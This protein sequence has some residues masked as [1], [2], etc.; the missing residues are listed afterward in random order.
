[1]PTTLYRAIS[2]PIPENPLGAI[3]GFETIQLVPNPNFALLPNVII[4]GSS[5]EFSVSHHISIDGTDFNYL[6]LNWTHIASTELSWPVVPRLS[7]VMPECNDFIY[8]TQ[9]FPWE[10]EILPTDVNITFELGVELFGDFATIEE[11]GLMFKV[12]IWLIDSSGNWHQVYR[13][14]PPYIATQ[15]V[16]HTNLNY[17]DIVESWGGMIQ[18]EDGV[19]EDPD[20]NLTIAVGLA[21]TAWFLEVFETEPWREYDG[22]VTATIS[23]LDLTVIL[24]TEADISPRLHPRS[25]NSLSSKYMDVCEDMCVT[26]DGAV[27]TVGTK[28]HYPTVNS[29][30][31]VKWDSQANLQWVQMW[32]G[33][34]FAS[35]YG[36]VESQGFV[37]TVGIDWSGHHEGDLVILKWDPSGELIWQESFDN[38]GLDCGRKIEIGEDGV[39]Y[40]VGDTWSPRYLT[41]STFLAKFDSEGNKLWF[42]EISAVPY[43]SWD[44][45]L[46]VA[47]TVE[48]KIY[49]MTSHYLTLWNADGDLQWIISTVYNDL[50]VGPDG[51]AYLVGQSYS[52]N[53]QLDKVNEIGELD[54][55]VTKNVSYGYLKESISGVSVDVAPDGSIYVVAEL[56]RY[57]LAYLLIKYDAEGQ[58]VW[59]RT[60]GKDS[61]KHAYGGGRVCHLSARGSGLLYLATT[62]LAEETEGNFALAIYDFRPTD[63]NLGLNTVN[64]GLYLAASTL[65]LFVIIDHARRKR[66]WNSG[67]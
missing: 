13:T 52:S 5:G 58:E 26:S 40:V 10:R 61:W 56:Y 59:N 55:S 12:Y 62:I 47:V 50:A 51:S 35:G 21:P 24:E 16:L 65:I 29:L 25:N 8:F 20:D 66:R 23:R 39:I 11:G 18:D 31:L 1:M 45:G 49:A 57:D 14:S 36:V 30:V 54:W 44:Q 34:T 53:M 2:V 27:Y 17:F 9:T 43:W 22:S 42:R 38:N 15:R 63:W 48:G 28:S 41:S 33:S 37:Y 32:N 7:D 6:L 46:D 60:I 4:E 19:Q 67:I 64:I 3:A